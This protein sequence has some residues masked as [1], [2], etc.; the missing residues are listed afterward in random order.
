MINFNYHTPTEVLFGKQTEDKTAEMIKKYGGTNVLIHFGS[1]SAIRLGLIQKITQQLDNQGIKYTILGGVVP[2]PRL[3][4]VKRGIEICKTNNIDFILAIGGGSV[5]DSSKAIAYGLKYQG[6]VWD[7]FCSRGQ[8]TQT[9]PVGAILT[10]PAAGSEMSDSCVI[11]NDENNL[12]RGYN[13]T[14]CRCK[15]AIMNPEFTYTLPQFQTACGAVDIMMHTMERYFS[16]DTDMPLTD[17]IAEALM[18]TVKN[19]TIE[20]ME[21]PSDYKHRAQIMWASSL[22]HNDLTG[23]GLTRDF[24]THKLEHELS[25]MFDVAHGAG[26]AALWS[27]WARYVMHCNPS[28]F[29]QFGTNVMEITPETSTEKTAL[30][31]IEEVE[32]FYKKINQPINIPQLLGRK[33]TTDEITTMAKNCSQNQTIKIGSFMKLDYNDMINIY[34]NANC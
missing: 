31:A 20:V 30:K 9:M 16:P 29:A 27:T 21:N 34:N 15:F 26:L 14:I 33:L 7:L 32:K 8:A 19:S 5:I 22:S 23:C 2:N 4:M 6:D 25:A 12:K 18:K 3:S 1:Q 28:R 11:T 24:A 17:A 10:I 13:N